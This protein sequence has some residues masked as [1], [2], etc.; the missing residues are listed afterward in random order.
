MVP[1]TQQEP[2]SFTLRMAQNPEQRGAL[3]TLSTTEKPQE[4]PV[5]LLHWNES[6]SIQFPFCIPVYIQTNNKKCNY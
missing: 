4:T 6:Y 5:M 2:K 3:K 1:P